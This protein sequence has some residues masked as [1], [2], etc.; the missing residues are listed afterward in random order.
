VLLLN[1]YEPDKAQ[2]SR[3][4]F[5][6]KLHKAEQPPPSTFITAQNCTIQRQACDDE[7]S[8]LESAN[9]IE[10]CCDQAKREVDVE[11]GNGAEP[12]YKGS[13]HSVRIEL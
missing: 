13:S 3:F 12:L 4:F 6:S 5:A 7:Y 2:A 11:E 1:I 9:G 8:W 10:L